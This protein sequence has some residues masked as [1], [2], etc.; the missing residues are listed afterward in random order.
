MSRPFAA[1]SAGGGSLSLDKAVGMN[2]AASDAPGMVQHRMDS[3][4]LCSVGVQLMAQ[5]QEG[6]QVVEHVN[7]AGAQPAVVAHAVMMVLAWLILLPVGE[8]HG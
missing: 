1:I 7:M 5:A 3:D 8:R 6:G 4:H 2:F